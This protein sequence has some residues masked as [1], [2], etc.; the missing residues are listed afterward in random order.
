MV[1]VASALGQRAEACSCRTPALLSGLVVPLNARLPVL[2]PFS[3]DTSFALTT[4]GGIVVP[5]DAVVVPGGFIVV[6]MQ[7][8]APDTGYLLTHGGDPE[9]FQTGSSVDELSPASPTILAN[10][11]HSVSPVL[12]RNSCNLGGEGFLVSLSSPVDGVLFQV[13]TGPTTASIDTSSPA[14]VL[15]VNPSASFFLG[16]SSVCGPRFPVSKMANLAIQVRTVDLA[17]NVSELSNAVQLKSSGCSA[18]GGST[19]VLAALL[20]FGKSLKRGPKRR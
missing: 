11:T 7:R 4:A 16:D 15:Q 2:D 1:V 20:L 3:T 6:P 10:F 18:T 12:G 5:A 9:S 13:F 19:L 14:M 17:G 8:L